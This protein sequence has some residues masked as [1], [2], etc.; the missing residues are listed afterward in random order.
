MKVVYNNKK[1][2]FR[3]GVNSRPE[4]AEVL[5]NL[6]VGLLED[7]ITCQHMQSAST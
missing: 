7:Y 3:E 5:W 4:P 1:E 6:L 2:L